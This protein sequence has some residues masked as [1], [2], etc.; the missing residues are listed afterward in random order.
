MFWNGGGRELAT[1]LEDTVEGMLASLS[2][3]MKGCKTVLVV[4]VLL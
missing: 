4:P 1:E 2:I 3:W